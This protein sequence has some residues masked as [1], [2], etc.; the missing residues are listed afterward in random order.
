M[1]LTIKNNF[2]TFKQDFKKDTGLDPDV[3][4]ETYI[5]Y[6]NA[7]IN[8]Y[9]MQTNAAMLNE[10]VNLPSRLSFELKQAN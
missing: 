5:A 6:Y 9:N 2:N 1:A 8:D 7:R 10:I 3:N 4:L